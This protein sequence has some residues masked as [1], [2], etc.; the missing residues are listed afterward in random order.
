MSGDHNQE[1]SEQHPCTRVTAVSL[2]SL[3]KTI[4]GAYFLG[5]HKPVSKTKRPENRIFDLLLTFNTS[6]RSYRFFFFLKGEGGR[7]ECGWV[8]AFTIPNLL[9]FYIH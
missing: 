2:T 7:V 1:L 6:S 5:A 3:L 8:R 9:H 4:F